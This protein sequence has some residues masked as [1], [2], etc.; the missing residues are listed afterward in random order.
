[1]GSWSSLA[2]TWPW[3]AVASSP[4]VTVSGVYPDKADEPIPPFETQAMVR[5]VSLGRCDFGVDRM[6]ELGADATAAVGSGGGNAPRCPSRVCRGCRSNRDGALLCPAIFPV[7]SVTQSVCRFR[8]CLRPSAQFAFLTPAHLNLPSG[9]VRFALCCL[10]PL[11]SPSRRKY[12]RP[13]RGNCALGALHLSSGLAAA[14]R[15]PRSARRR[16]Q[17]WEARRSKTG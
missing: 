10:A 13:A 1:M 2:W 5:R 17:R 7:F 12:Q 8:A 14:R 9:I 15:R 3:H 4:A 11:A 6:P 16:N